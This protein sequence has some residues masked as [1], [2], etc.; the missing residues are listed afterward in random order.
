ML[1]FESTDTELMWE[2]QRETK[3]C[4]HQDAMRWK[5]NCELAL[6]K[7]KGLAQ[8]RIRQAGFL[9]HG[10][11]DSFSGGFYCEEIPKCPRM[12]GERKESGKDPTG[13]VKELWAGLQHAEHMSQQEL[14]SEQVAQV[15]LLPS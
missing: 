11:S 7:K 9:H 1:C 5:Q 3:T 6:K 2:G 10:I 8:D 4:M 12:R 13:F 14:G 15:I